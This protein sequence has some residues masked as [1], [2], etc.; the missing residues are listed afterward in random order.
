MIG[1]AVVI[2]A[3]PH[4]YNLSPSNI[5]EGVGP[6]ATVKM[7]RDAIDGL[8]E[9]ERHMPVED[10]WTDWGVD[11]FFDTMFKESQTDLIVN[12]HLPLYSWFEDGLCSRAKNAELA[13]RWPTR[14]I[15]YAG[16]DPLQGVSRCIDSLDEQIEECSGTTLGLK[17]YPHQIDPIMA[18]RL[19]DEALAF[20]I[21]EHAVSRGIRSIA[22]HK[23]VPFGPFPLDP[24]RLDDIDMAAAAFPHV[25]FEIVHAGWAF[26]EEAALAIM[27]FPNVYANLE[28]TTLILRRRPRIFVDILAQLLLAGGS[29][30]IFWATG[31]I[32]QHP[33]TGLQA[34]ADLAFDTETED[35][36]QLTLTAAAKQDILGRSYA[37]MIGLDLD[38]WQARAAD[39]EVSKHRA[40]HGLDA[41]YANWV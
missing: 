11:H 23:A 22:I 1:D 28:S 17:F 9:G 19:D 4:S 36:Y 37:A 39:D 34:F 29:R 26:T 10:F 8:P 20:P 21:I 24:Y 16:V 6:A 33:Q 14:V 40:E 18:W 15:T 31:N 12:H 41:P 38:S 35:R 5:R 25:A 3:A 13:R 27:R 30:K 2:D 7:M 32:A